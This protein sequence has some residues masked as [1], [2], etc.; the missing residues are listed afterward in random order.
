MLKFLNKLERLSCP[1]SMEKKR[2]VIIITMIIMAIILTIIMM[3]TM[4][5]IIIKVALRN[6]AVAC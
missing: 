5:G 1:I 6:A 2:A 4:T 3:I